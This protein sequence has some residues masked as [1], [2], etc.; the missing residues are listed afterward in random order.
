MFSTRQNFLRVFAECSLSPEI[1]G[2]LGFEL[3]GMLSSA[4]NHRIDLDSFPSRNLSIGRSVERINYRAVTL[5]IDIPDTIQLNDFEVRMS[6]A[7]ILFDRGALTSGQAAQIAGISKR[8]FIELVGKY[9]VSIF[10]YDED[11]FMEE[12]E[13]L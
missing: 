11:E 9:G 4:E 2:V 10:Q 7:A 5:Q 13:Q 8:S 12:L 3:C 1:R 6:L